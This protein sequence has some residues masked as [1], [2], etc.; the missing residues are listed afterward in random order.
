MLEMSRTRLGLFASLALGAAHG[1][2]MLGAAWIRGSSE[3]PVA[4]LCVLTGIMTLLLCSSAVTA[5]FIG[6]WAFGRRW[7]LALLGVPILL[8]DDEIP[9]IPR[10]ESLRFSFVL[11]AVAALN[12][13]ALDRGTMESF[14]EYYGAQGYTRTVLRGG[15]PELQRKVL[16][17][18]AQEPGESLAAHATELLIPTAKAGEGEALRAAAFE[19]LGV[20]GERM[21]HSADLIHLGRSTAGGWEIEL[22]KAL[23]EDALKAAHACLSERPAML[24]KNACVGAIEGLRAPVSIPLLATELRRL[25]ADGS[26]EALLLALGGMRGLL[27]A[28]VP[29]VEILRD[30]A[31]PPR[32]RALAAHGIGEVVGHWRPNV[33]EESRAIPAEVTAAAEAMNAVGASLDLH[34]RCTVVEALRKMRDARTAPVLFEIF[35][36]APA[37][38]RCP[39]DSLLRPG[40]RE[41]QMSRDEGL[42]IRTLRA[43]AHIAKDNA[44]VHEWLSRTS[45]GEGLSPTMRREMS[46][47][48]IRAGEGGQ[49]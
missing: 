33:L 35:E 47:L 43:I 26:R 20:V 30:P 24:L 15:E 36:G 12:G 1:A 27:R 13:T 5:L 22:L 19:A 45:E 29:L 8:E 44:T 38:V 23:R 18:M 3:S 49:E 6:E 16:L 42:Q 46:A 4:D 40:R 14:T 21:S 32:E 28:V 41:V 31:R 11:I 10:N 25:E 34:G 37:D 48:R 2:G 39:T 7:R 9:E 17:E